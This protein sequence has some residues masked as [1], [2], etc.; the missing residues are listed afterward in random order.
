MFDLKASIKN[1][2]WYQRYK[3]SEPNVVAAISTV[4][5]MMHRFEVESTLLLQ[6]SEKKSGLWEVYRLE[7]NS[8][9]QVLIVI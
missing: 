3:F 4:F 2:S 5:C 9:L 8:V 1:M 6:W 7:L